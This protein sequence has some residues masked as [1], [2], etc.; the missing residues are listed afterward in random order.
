MTTRTKKTPAERELAALARFNGALETL[1]RMP[2]EK[3]S[4]WGDVGKKGKIR[5]LKWVLDRH[6][7]TPEDLS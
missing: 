4:Y 5:A 3:Q 6:G 2:V 1:G 7:I